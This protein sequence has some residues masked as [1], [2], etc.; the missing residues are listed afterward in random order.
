M[1]PEIFSLLGLVLRGAEAGPGRP[2]PDSDDDL[3]RRIQRGEPRLFER[4]LD[5]HGRRV[6]GFVRRMVPNPADA[7]EL[8]QDCFIRAHAALPEYQPR[9][10]FCAWLLTIAR[11]LCYAHWKKQS[12][13]G[14]VATDPEILAELP[15]PTL[16]RLPADDVGAWFAG[17][18]L[19]YR[20]ILA[21]KYA[22]GLS[23]AEIAQQ[24]SLSEAAVKQRLHRGREMI[25]E[26]LQ[27]L[28][29]PWEQE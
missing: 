2:S 28:D 17:L 12:R 9:G 25:R 22:S 26:R 14:A 3:V 1:L 13:S 29:A 19:E 4:L 6:Y 18:P 16:E 24:E 20:T 11:H 10:S 23:I 27:D 7:E 8:S 21:L 15:A 5:R